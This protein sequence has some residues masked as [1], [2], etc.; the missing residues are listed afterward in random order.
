[1]STNRPYEDPA[2]LAGL[3]IYDAES[4]RLFHAKDKRGGRGVGHVVVSAGAYADTCTHS[5]NG[6]R[7]VSVTIDGRCRHIGAHRVAWILAHGVIPDGLQVDH[8][9][10]IRDDNRLCNLR[11][12]TNRENSHNRR[13]AKGYRWHKKRGKW[14][15]S[16][17]LDGRTIHLGLFATEAEARAAYLSAKRVY[18]PTSPVVLKSYWQSPVLSSPRLNLT[19]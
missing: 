16:I 1:M 2:S 10:G 6:Y 11:L 7:Q 5:T 15:S 12:V 3:F 9:N 13:S 19:F 14:H 8:I 18:H 17:K 4:G